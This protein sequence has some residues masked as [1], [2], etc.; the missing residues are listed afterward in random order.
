MFRQQG[1]TPTHAAQHQLYPPAPREGRNRG[2]RF[3]GGFFQ[4]SRPP[5]AKARPSQREGEQAGRSSPTPP[6]PSPNATFGGAKGDVVSRRALAAGLGCSANKARRLHIQPSTTFT[7]PNATFAGAKGDFLSRK[8]LAAGLG[9]F[10][11]KARRLQIQPSTNFTLPL[12]GRVGI[13]ERDSG[14]GSSK[15]RALPSLRLDPPGGRVNRQAHPAQHHRHP[16]RT[17][18][19][20][21]SL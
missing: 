17:L 9:C 7:L 20:A 14:E 18:L 6:S 16:P 1:P 8:A 19:S 15:T 13:E 11:S 21:E 5:L 4:D 2:T 12:R 3:R 10:A